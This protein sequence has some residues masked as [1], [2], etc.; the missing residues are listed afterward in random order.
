MIFRAITFALA[1]ALTASV[2]Q[3]DDIERLTRQS[4]QSHLAGYVSGAVL[5]PVGATGDRADVDDDPAA[6]VTHGP[7]GELHGEEWPAQVDIPR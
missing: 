4:K 1:V 7:P 2:A 5:Q 6:L 3:A